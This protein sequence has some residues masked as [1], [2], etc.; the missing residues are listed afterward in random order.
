MVPV[1]EV[2]RKNCFVY[3]GWRPVS[4]NVA[5]EE[6][7]SVQV[8]SYFGEEVGEEPDSRERAYLVIVSKRVSTC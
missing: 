7:L 8:A 3:A 6:A 4:G 5:S 2:G 1:H